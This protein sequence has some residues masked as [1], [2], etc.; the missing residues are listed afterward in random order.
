MCNYITESQTQSASITEGPATYIHTFNF[1]S[2]IHMIQKDSFGGGG[3]GG[4]G[5]FSDPYV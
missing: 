1:R 4:G 3:G 5:A 2:V